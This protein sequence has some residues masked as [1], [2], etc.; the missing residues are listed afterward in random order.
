MV[1]QQ[2]EQFGLV[3][4]RQSHTYQPADTQS[5]SLINRVQASERKPSMSNLNLPNIEGTILRVVTDK[6]EAKVKAA[7]TAATISAF[8]LSVLGSYVCSTARRRAGRRP[9]SRPVVRH[10]G[11]A[12][13]DGHCPPHACRKH[14]TTISNRTQVTTAGAAAALKR[15]F[16]D[17]S[18]LIVR[19]QGTFQVAD[20][21]QSPLSGAIRGDRSR[22][23]ALPRRAVDPRVL[24]RRVDRVAGAAHAKP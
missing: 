11:R 23:F 4:S 8:A 19:P 18:P 7:T 14:A 15:S 13:N 10:I 20:L 6:V 24:R 1:H 2:I 3:V 16:I 21:G 22:G 5:R 9:R 17:L 12:A